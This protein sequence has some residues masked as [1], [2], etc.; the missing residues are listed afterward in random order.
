MVMI[1]NFEEILRTL[2]MDLSG[3]GVGK[4]LAVYQYLE[5]LVLF[6][7]HRTFPLFSHWLS[8][9]TRLI[10]FALQLTS[11]IRENIIVSVHKKD[12]GI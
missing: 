10:K 9:L 8:K 6:A 4:E 1:E 2:E 11:I 3:I 12:N 5:Y 7:L